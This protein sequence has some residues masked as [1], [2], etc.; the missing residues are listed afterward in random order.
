MNIVLY[1][2]V[3]GAQEFDEALKDKASQVT[4]IMGD[5][6]TTGAG[7]NLRLTG[8]YT[9]FEHVDGHV[10][11]LAKL[12]LLDYGSRAENAPKHPITG[13]PMTSYE[14]YFVDQS[15]Y[16]GEQNVRM[17]TQKGRSMIRRCVAGMSEPAMDFTGNNQYIA[18]EQDKSSCT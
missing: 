7:R 17:V 8:F 11:T 4:Q 3:G 6:F 18:T 9:S 15:M 12:P 1:T 5:K 10:I 16:D 14:M 13:L 2:G